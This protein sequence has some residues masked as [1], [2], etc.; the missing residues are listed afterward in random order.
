MAEPSLDVSVLIVNY[1]SAEVVGE[2][3]ASVFAQTGLSLEVIVVDNRS[4]DHSLDLLR[5]LDGIELIESDT[6]L[7]FGRANNLAFTRARGRVLH[8]LNP[9]ARLGDAGALRLALDHL[10]A[11]PE[12]GLL[13]TRLLNPDGSDQWRPRLRYP[14]QRFAPPGFD[15][16][17]P[18]EI[19]WVI[20]ASLVVRREVFQA[21]GGFDPDYFLY[22]EE[23]D[24]CLRV[25]RAGHTI[26]F[27]E[28]VRVFHHDGWSERAAPRQEVWRRKQD[29]L[30]LFY[31]KAYGREAAVRAVRHELRR[32][33]LRLITLGL[34]RRLGRA[35]AGKESKYR[36]VVEAAEAWLAR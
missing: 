21:I 9:D 24:L 5:R 12:C 6:N 30:L 34:Q 17:L 35:D 29:G 16:E 22:A 10:D 8:L 23:T 3:I 15:A 36:A 1:G 33:R 11:H 19:A 18:G 2:A 25:R 14:G 4:P 31:E 28:E 32:A 26:R 13:G 20:G 7:G 27:A